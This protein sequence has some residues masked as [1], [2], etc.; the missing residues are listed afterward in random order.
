ME[1][2]S[3]SILPTSYTGT[4]LYYTIPGSYKYLTKKVRLA[5]FKIRLDGGKRSGYF[6]ARGIYSI[7]KSISFLDK[8]GQIV[9]AMY[10]TDY[11]ALKMIH[12]NNPAQRDVNRILFQNSALAVEVPSFS[13]LELAEK[14]GMMPI[15]QLG[16]Y[17]DLSFMS[18]YLLARNISDDFLQIQI[19]LNNY[20]Y[21]GQA[22]S[23]D[24]APTLYVDEVLTGQPVDSQDV[25]LY[26]MIV[27][28]KIP[29]RT[30]NLLAVDDPSDDWSTASLSKI[31]TRMNSYTNQMI[32]NLYMYPLE[33]TA[34]GTPINNGFCQSLQETAINLILDGKVIMPF[35]GLNSD[36]RRLA[37]I[38][39]MTGDMHL[40]A[41]ESYYANMAA[42]P[43]SREK[44]GL[45]NEN[46]G[47]KYNGTFGYSCVGINNVVVGELTL[48]FAAKFKQADVAK[49]LFI[50]ALAEV[51]RFY[52]RSTSQV[53]N[54]VGNMM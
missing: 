54:F 32:T 27:P 13:Q 15:T 1:A 43:Y 18:N 6:D 39:D 26:D 29:I 53:G 33:N 16:S 9:D 42:V 30:D 3:L 37:H 23:L 36:A 31:D 21:N 51:K 14:R 41:V 35:G 47:R 20:D 4:Q 17:L 44:L 50:Q 34:N 48:Q 19:E 52:K 2:R 5:D 45:F 12:Q 40:P 28:D 22:I 46:L 11:M 49:P 7:I 38:T 24:K 8:Q 10:N 25:I